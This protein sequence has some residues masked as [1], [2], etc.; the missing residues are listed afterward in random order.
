MSDRPAVL[1]RH[2]EN[3]EHQHE[4]AALG[5]WVFL[6][7]EIMFFGGLFTAYAVYRAEYL[8]SFIAGS[9]LLEVKLGATNTLVLILSSYTMALAVHAA[10]LGKRKPLVGF[11]LLTLLLG[12]VFLGIKFIEYSEKFRLHL[13]PGIDFAPA[14]S[15]PAHTEL[16]LYLYFIMTLVHA[17]HLLIG[18]CLV[19]V[20]AVRAKQAAFSASYFTPVEV[21][22]LYW[23]F[24]D[25][26]WIFLFPLLY[27][28]QLR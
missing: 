8:P 16:F 13:V 18:I 7:T 21:T 3:L 12:C 22:G 20:L 23:H 4:A 24:V 19:G 15:Y 17:L 9:R 26:V 6:I 11:L 10:Q 25:I 14:Q 28:I 5:M 2:F 1:A 27:L